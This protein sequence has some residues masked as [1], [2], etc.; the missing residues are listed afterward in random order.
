VAGRIRLLS[1]RV[2]RAPVHVVVSGDDWGF[3]DLELQRLVLTLVRE[4]RGLMDNWDHSPLLVAVAPWGE[5]K[6]GSSTTHGSG[7]VNAFSLLLTPGSTLQVASGHGAHVVRFLAHEMFHQWTG[8]RI[9]E[10]EPERAGEWFFEGFTD[11][12]ARRMLRRTGLIDTAAA[13]A[14]ANRVLARYWLNPFRSV[15]GSEALSGRGLDLELQPGTAGD[16]GRAGGGWRRWPPTGVLPAPRRLRQRAVAA[17]G[18]R[19]G[20]QRCPLMS[21]A[22]HP[23]S[24]ARYG[25]AGRL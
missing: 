14:D 24:P 19:D 12:Y 21:W 1:A 13:V 17:P 9:P 6:P 4:I 7:F 8:R 23:G 25:S 16:A 20:V 11:F 22:I 15:K 5:K 18:A 3:I 10:G 2:R